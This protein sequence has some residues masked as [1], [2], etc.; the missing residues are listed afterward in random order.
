MER[1][2]KMITEELK[3][4]FGEGYE[5]TPMEKR[6]NN[7]IVLHGICIY[8]KGEKISPVVYVDAY[9]K[10]YERGLLGIPQIADLLRRNC[11]EKEMPEQVPD[12]I[13]DYSAMKSRIRLAVI[14]YQANTVELEDRPHRRFLD[15]AVVYYMDMKEV[16][17]KATCAVTNRIMAFWGTSEPDLFRQGCE[18]Q[19]LYDTARIEGFDDIL[20]EMLQENPDEE[21]REIL[22]ELRAGAAQPPM[23]VA[24]NRKR[25]YGACCILD[26]SFLQGVADGMASNLV[27]YPSSLHELVIV[28]KYGEEDVMGSSGVAEIN[29]TAVDAVEQLSNSVY[30]FD[31]EKGEVSIYQEGT[32]LM[33]SMRKS[34]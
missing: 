27:I 31:R 15:L 25:N 2:V 10:D 19:R 5:I 9:Y 23:F 12:G 8:K 29:S 26:R 24:S 18:N 33:E 3:K 11:T 17:E 1:F 34:A 6:K 30:L 16:D 22:A 4:Q 28:P 13:T 7:G 21:M 32:P 20:E 14:N